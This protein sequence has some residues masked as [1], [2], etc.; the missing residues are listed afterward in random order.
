M[1]YFDNASTTPICKPAFD[2]A[3]I[4]LMEYFANPSSLH[5]I[6]FEAEKKVEEARSI[7]AEKIK[8]NPEEI[9]FT[10]GG[11]EANNTA[12]IGTAQSY[13]RKGNKVITVKTEHP[14]VIESFN[15]LKRQGFDVLYA[16]IDDKGY[17]IIEELVK[18][19][20]NDVILVS[21]MHVNNEIGV[22]QNIE[23]IGKLIKSKN[24]EVIFHVD[25]VQGFGKHNISLKYIDLLTMSSHKI[26]GPKGC[27]AL[28]IKKGTRLKS[29][30]LGGFQQKAIRPGTENTS[31]IY[32][33]GIACKLAYDN[34]EKNLYKVR[35]VK[36]ALYD[37]LADLDGVY[38]NGDFEN[39]SPYILSLSFEGIRGE[40]LL[41]SLEENE[42][43]VSTGSACSSKSKKHK[44]VIDFIDKSKT[45][46][47]VRFSF[48]ALNTKA[49]AE[50]CAN[51][52]KKIVPML[53]QYKRR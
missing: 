38:V 47:T 14:S 29:I 37:G 2:A 51:H 33:M 18:M 26:H 5:R 13:K 40:V 50:F 24:P 30:I 44:S 42:I 36:T 31:G 3:N 27:G 8:A 15:E 45:E 19:I 46:G 16:P 32:A 11:T 53:R 34:I 4:M 41:H 12:V 7:I 48:S 21:I 49:E 52:I 20:S 22:I 17:I 28:Y 6:G 23:E 9:I 10:S 1:I 43:Y 35:E 25:N 39:G